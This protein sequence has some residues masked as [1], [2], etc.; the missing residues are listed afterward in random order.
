MIDSIS[1]NTCPTCYK[2][3][4]GGFKPENYVSA[5]IIGGGFGAVNT[6]LELRQ[7]AKKTGM[8]LKQ[9]VKAFSENSDGIVKT[10]V[11]KLAD[12]AKT[13][14]KFIHSTT[15][16]KNIAGSAVDCACFC[17]AFDAIAS[18]IRNKK[19]KED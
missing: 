15:L 1:A 13:V 11:A 4:E 5:A 3:K 16:L 2:K 19:H 12:N 14:G 6:G 18:L 7:T 8:S 17:I 9:M 10:G